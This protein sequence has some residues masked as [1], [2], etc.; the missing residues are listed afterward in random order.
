MAKPIIVVSMGGYASISGIVVA[1]AIKEGG[2]KTT[3]E[4]T[5][6]PQQDVQ[7]STVLIA[8]QK[9][10]AEATS[11]S[12]IKTITLIVLTDNTA[13]FKIVV[14]AFETVV[15]VIVTLIYN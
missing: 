10:S 15:Y 8:N 11:T 3:T 4:V 1:E 9:T 12:Q 13:L 7:L 5:E 6:T 2:M 14:A